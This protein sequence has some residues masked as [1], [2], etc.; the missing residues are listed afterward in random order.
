MAFEPLKG[1][2]LVTREEQSNT[3]ASG[4]YIPDSAKE[5]PL[6]GKVVA[7]GPKAKEDGISVG[8]TVVFG[9]YSGSE[10]TI[11]NQEYLIL[12]SKEILGLIK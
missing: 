10:I 12:E 7:V 1:R 11:E 2:V 5:K 6:E 8:D 3:T 4:L 9:K